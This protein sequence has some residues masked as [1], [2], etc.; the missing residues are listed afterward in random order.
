MK[1]TEFYWVY[2]LYHIYFCHSFYCCERLHL[3]ICVR[4]TILASLG[5]IPLNYMKLYLSCAVGL[6][7]LV[8]CWNVFASI[9]ITDICGIRVSLASGNEFLK[10]LPFQFFKIVWE[11]SVWIFIHR[12]VQFSPLYNQKKPYDYRLSFLGAFFI[13]CSILFPLMVYSGFVSLF[14]FGRLYASQN[15]F[16]YFRFSSLLVHNCS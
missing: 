10:V 11:K 3:F 6:N 7:L 5:Y 13:T 1:G 9:F 2:F 14:S 12:L 4:W 8:I 15:L 16:I